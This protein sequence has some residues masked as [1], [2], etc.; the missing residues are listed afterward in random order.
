LRSLRAQQIP[1]IIATRTN[2]TVG[3]IITIIIKLEDS[4]VVDVVEFEVTLVE[5][6]EVPAA[7]AEEVTTVETEKAVVKSPAAL[8][9][10]T[11][12]DRFCTKRSRIN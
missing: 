4:L 9:A 3:T 10:S 1:R 2:P 12:N 5:P 8:M 11:T 7:D 6:D